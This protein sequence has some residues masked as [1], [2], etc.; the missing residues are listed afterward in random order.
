MTRIEFA[1]QYDPTCRCTVSY[2]DQYGYTH[3]GLLLDDIQESRS[4]KL[5]VFVD[6]FSK[7]ILLGDVTEV[8]P[9]GTWES[10]TKRGT[11]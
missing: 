3:K 2:K 8:A 5:F 1:R 7:R 4:G 11:T 9:I 6:S 10:L